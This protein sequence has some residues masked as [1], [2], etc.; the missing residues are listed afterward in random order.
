M[1]WATRVKRLL[2]R[3]KVVGYT[4][5]VGS[6]WRCPIDVFLKVVKFLPDV[7]YSSDGSFPAVVDILAFKDD[8]VGIEFCLLDKGVADKRFFIDGVEVKY[9]GAS[10]FIAYLASRRRFLPSVCVYLPEHNSFLMKWE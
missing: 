4:N 1:D 8:L 5:G 3:K 7:E 10:K 9:A 2:K 6:W